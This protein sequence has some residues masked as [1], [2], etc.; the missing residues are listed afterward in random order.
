MYVLQLMSGLQAYPLRIYPPKQ[1]VHFV[2]SEIEHS[3]HGNLQKDLQ[4]LS[5]NL[6]DDL[7]SKQTPFEQV[8]QFYGHGLHELIA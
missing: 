3:L 1:E 5:T 2:A 4:I 8:L 6:K 7:H